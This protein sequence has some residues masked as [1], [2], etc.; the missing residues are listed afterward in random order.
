M[1]VCGGGAYPLL[2]VKLAD[3][4]LCFDERVC[5]FR[6]PSF[7]TIFRSPYSS[8]PLRARSSGGAPG[9][10]GGTG[11]A[12]G[13]AW[14]A[15]TGA[16]AAHQPQRRSAA[17]RGEAGRPLCSGHHRP[18]VPVR[19]GH[20]VRGRFFYREKRG[21]DR[22]RGERKRG[23]GDPRAACAIR[24][25]PR[26]VLFLSPSLF[27]CARRSGMPGARTGCRRRGCWTSSTRRSWTSTCCS[28][29]PSASASGT[30]R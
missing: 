24:D 11:G 29:P 7:L 30:R 22:E 21:G 18:P 27:V 9:G 13:A 10:A 17:A 8:C 14:G 5:A 6:V 25:H 1:C 4:T 15:V 2:R 23:D 12:G 3:G 20:A 16:R 19:R 26:R 28:T